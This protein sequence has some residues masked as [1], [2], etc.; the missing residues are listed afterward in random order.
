MSNFLRISHA[1]NYLKWLIF[2]KAI[3]KVKRW[4]FCESRCSYFTAERGARY[5]V[6]HVWLHVYPLEYLKNHTPKLGVW[7]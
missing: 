5:C 2:D 6:Q 3:Q 7:F 1:K 4:T